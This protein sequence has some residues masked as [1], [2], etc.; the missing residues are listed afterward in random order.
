MNKL[1]KKLLFVG[2]IV[3]VGISTIQ[4]QAPEIQ[5]QK[6]IGGT[7]TDIAYSII[8]T[9]DNG[10]IVAGNSSSNNGDVSGNHGLG[11]YLVVKLS[12]TGNIEWQKSLGGTNEDDARS[13]QQTLDGGY[14][15]VGSSNSNNG[16]VSGNHGGADYW[17]VKLNSIGDI[18]W[19]KSLGGLSN[20]GANS[21]KETEDGGY[22]IAGTSAS[23]NSDVS[24]N[25]GSIDYWIVKINIEGNIEWQKC[26]GGTNQD[27]LWSITQSF[28]GGYVI[29]G[30]SVSNDGDV[31]GN[32]GGVDYW[33]VKINSIGTIE[34]Q[35]SLG[36][37]NDD[38]PFSITQTIDG[39]YIIAGNSSSNDGDVSGNHGYVDCWIVKINSIGI[40]EWQKSLGGSNQDFVYSIIQISDGSYVI[41]GNSSSND[42]DVSGNY[43][44]LDCWMVKI[45]S[46]GT[47]IWQKSLG[48]TGN[49][50]PF[51]II[52]TLNGGYIIAGYSDSNNGDVTGNNGYEDFL[53]VKLSQDNLSTNSFLENNTISLFPNPTKE[54]LSIK[55]DYYTPL[56]EI[57]ITDVL[58]KIIH[59]QKVDGLITTIITDGFKNGVYFVNTMDGAKMFTQ[60]FIK[61]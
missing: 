7:G 52:Q 10:F 43:G 27:S 8:Q 28:D 13:I 24:G 22:I 12:V 37:S 34:W 56:Q 55:L 14:I 3:Y 20:E 1:L 29:V 30:Y 53:I 21:I 45:N 18:Q 9:S 35:K 17:I 33:I 60:R 51:S 42:E 46:S 44:G 38:I 16:D 32:H 6:S 36:G 39:G 49:D 11:D 4:A 5:W 61:I 50:I 15:V 26:F 31:S 58:G 48:G 57:I 40:I 59:S 2:S 23:T 54:S 25:H 19:Q 41:A 47:I